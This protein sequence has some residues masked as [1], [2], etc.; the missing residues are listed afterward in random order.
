MKLRLLVPSLLLAA[1]TATGCVLVSGQFLVT[2]DLDSPLV[3][4]SATNINGLYIDL[5]ENEDY[6][7]HKDKIKDLAD[8]ALL[9]TV[10]NTGG[11]EL[12]LDVYMFE[13]PEVARPL[14]AIIAGQKVWG[15][16]TV[17]AGQSVTLDWDQSAALLGA[18]KAPL[19]DAIKAGGQFT[20]YA[21]SN[22]A[23]FSFTFTNGIFVAVIAA[24]Q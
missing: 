13:G 7:D 22:T 19:L 23:P 16:L 11:T 2:L 6:E 21:V 18:G 5:T 1:L 15:T 10:N 17:P 9:G 8:F 20:F 14:A 3:V 4:N 24:G 12:K